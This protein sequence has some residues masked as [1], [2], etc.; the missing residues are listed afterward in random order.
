[1]LANL[2]LDRE[3]ARVPSET[4]HPKT[5]RLFKS[6]HRI[7]C[8]RL[9]A[10]EPTTDQLEADVNS[11]LAQAEDLDG[12]RQIDLALLERYSQ[13]LNNRSRESM[14]D[15]LEETKSRLSNHLAQAHKGFRTYAKQPCPQ[16]R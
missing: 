11:A 9:S 7:F 14:I 1:M 15:V 10:K 6:K 5:I 3:I 13:A 2:I 16:T 8:C 4:N 12:V